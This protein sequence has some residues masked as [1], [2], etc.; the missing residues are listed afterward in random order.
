MFLPPEKGLLASYICFPTILSFCFSDS[1]STRTVTVS[2]VT[3]YSI[4]AP[5]FGQRSSVLVPSADLP[6]I[7]PQQLHALNNLIIP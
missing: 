1:L 7:W 4:S 5:H 2:P 3:Q 6:K